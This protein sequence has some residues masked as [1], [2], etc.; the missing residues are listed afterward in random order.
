MYLYIL[1]SMGQA[2]NRC[3]AEKET[4]KCKKIIHFLTPLVSLNMAV[5]VTTVTHSSVEKY[6]RYKSK[7][8][9]L[10]NLDDE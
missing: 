3:Y 10:Y 4:T 1:L 2:K 8:A 7:S 5:L 6:E 9:V